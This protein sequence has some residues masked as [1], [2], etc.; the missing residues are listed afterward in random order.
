MGVR[1][2]QEGDYGVLVTLYKSFFKT[3]NI[4]QQP[5]KTIMEYL[6]QQSKEN[7]L[8]VYDDN[9][10]L[11]GALYL[12]NLSQNSSH[13]LWKFKHVAFESETI[14]SAL[15]EEAEKRVKGTSTSVKIELTIAESEDGIDFYK[16][17]GYVQ[18][19]ALSNHYRKGE[20]CFILSKSL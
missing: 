13:V 4:F 1:N 7:E 6:K 17:N 20:T 5:D 16:S 12:V 10:S 3:H 18:E 15:L 14:A 8:I 11:K 2:V 9:E 19:G